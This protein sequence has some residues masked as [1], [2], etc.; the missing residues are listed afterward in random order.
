MEKQRW[1]LWIGTLMPALAAAGGMNAAVVTIENT[2]PSGN[3]FIQPPVVTGAG[4]LFGNGGIVL[5]NAFT[6]PV[7]AALSQVSVVVEYV[8]LPTFGV[9]GRS[10]ML[11]TLFTDSGDSPGTPIES[12]TV[13]LNPSDTSLTIVTVNSMTNALLIAGRQYWLSEV[14]TSASNTGIGWG[15]AGASPG[16][17]PVLPVAEATTGVNAG[18]GPTQVNIANEFSVTATT[19]PEAGAFWT[20]LFV[21]SLIA[22]LRVKSPASKIYSGRNRLELS[23]GRACR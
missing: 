3:L 17:G 8:D 9:T 10:P 11:L 5:A 22:G 18:W 19:V 14:P 15:L 16:T 21:L 6:A 2:I 4:S 13:P 12:W 20:V 1:M 23:L 7:S